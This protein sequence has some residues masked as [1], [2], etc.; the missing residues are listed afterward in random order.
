M[1]AV[2]K[3]KYVFFE[4]ITT[5]PVFGKDVPSKRERKPHQM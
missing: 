5:Y 4:K 2:K 1:D 3:V